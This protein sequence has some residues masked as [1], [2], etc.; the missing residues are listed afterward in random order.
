MVRLRTLL[1]PQLL[2]AVTFSMPEVNEAEKS[3]VTFV[4]PCPL[5]MAALAG[6]VQL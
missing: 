4:V 1:V 6:A 2:L 5:A 3:T